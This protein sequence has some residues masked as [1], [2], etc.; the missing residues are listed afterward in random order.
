MLVR[1]ID[2]ASTS[3]HTLLPFFGKV[4]VG[5]YPANGVVLGLSKAARLAKHF[6]KKLQS[7]Q[8][9]AQDLLACLVH[10]LQPFG[11]AVCVVAQHLGSGPAAGVE[12]VTAGSGAFQAPSSPGMQV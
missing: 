1:D 12:V 4:H 6:S 9:F 3:E 2:F 10:H 7:Q 8:R 5:Y 11:A